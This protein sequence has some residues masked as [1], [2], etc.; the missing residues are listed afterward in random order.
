MEEREWRESVKFLALWGSAML[1]PTL[2]YIQASPSNLFVK[3]KSFRVAEKVH[4][5]DVL[6]ARCTVRSHKPC[7]KYALSSSQSTGVDA[8]SFLENASIR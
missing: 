6:L 1:L 3:T 4:T 5:L 2:Y 7:T 8:H